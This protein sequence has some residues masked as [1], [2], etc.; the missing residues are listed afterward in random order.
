MLKFYNQYF[1]LQIEEATKNKIDFLKNIIIDDKIYKFI[2][3]DDNEMLNNIKLDSFYKNSLWFSY[4]RKLNDPTEY[5]IKYNVKKVINKTG[6]KKESILFLIETIKQLYD[7]CSFSY[8]NEEYMWKEYA[9]EKQGICL[10]FDVINYDMLYPVEYLEK[11]NI[12]YD[13]MII[14]S[15]RAQKEQEK[16]G[17]YND[18]MALYPWLI[19]NP[20]NGEM[21]STKEKEV[22]ILYCPYEKLE[23]N[24]GRIAP[25]VKTY[26]NFNGI[27]VNYSDVGLKLK[28]VIIGNR[29]NNLI[30]EKVAVIA[31]SKGIKI[32]YKVN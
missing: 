18:P 10:I 16:I 17:K 8:R 32:V 20:Y 28:E 27:N 24:D 7:V 21:D 23:F 13:K 29:C 1:K 3:F 22:R 9:N 14:N 30:K 6:W 31:K 4:Y 15:L 2:A 12:N 19:K 5:E 25:H 26:K 11:K